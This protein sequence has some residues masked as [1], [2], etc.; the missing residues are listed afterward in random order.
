MSVGR[1]PEEAEALARVIAGFP[2]R[3]VLSDRRSAHETWGP[4]AEAALAREFEFGEARLDSGESLEGAG[5][6]SSGDGRHGS[7]GR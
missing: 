1:A 3:R 4:P 2:P 7:F 5:R 6:F